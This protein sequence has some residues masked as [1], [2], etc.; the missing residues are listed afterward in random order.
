M[1]SKRMTWEEIVKTYPDVW[2]AIQNPEKDG[3]TS[4]VERSIP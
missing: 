2:V 3:P 1:A 4:L